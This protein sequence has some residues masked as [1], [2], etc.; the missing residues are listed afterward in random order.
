MGFFD[1]ARN[2]IMDKFGDE[3]VRKGTFGV[4]E[5]Q[6]EPKK[7]A[8]KAP[9]EPKPKVEKP[10]PFPKPKRQPKPKLPKEPRKKV[11]QHVEEPEEFNDDAFADFEESQSTPI[12][13]EP[14]ISAPIS[15]SDLSM[16]ARDE[17][18]SVED[19]L[20]SMSIK[21]TF[22]INDGILFLDEELANQSFATQ[23][24][25]GYDMG[26]VDF[27]LS[28]TQRSVAEYVKLLR[29]RNDDVV[30]LARR[31]SDM[32]VEIN[33]MRFN[34]EVANGINIMANSGDDDALVVDLQEAR[35]KAQRLQ[36]ELEK[37]KNSGVEV[38]S[39]TDKIEQLKN[40]L[41]AE[42]IENRR[43]DTELQDLRAHLVLLEEEYDI[44]VFSERG[45]IQTPVQNGYDSYS[46]RREGEFKNVEGLSTRAQDDL[47]AEEKSYQKVGRDHWLPVVEE[48]LP[49]ITDIEES[50][51]TEDALPIEEG[52]P[53][54][55]DDSEEESLDDFA[56]D[57]FENDEISGNQTTPNESFQGSAFTANPYQDIEEFIESNISHFP[58][59]S[60]YENKD[61]DPDEDGF[62]YSFERN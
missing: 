62:N 13:D 32:M 26:E 54:F 29:V 34:S 20:K 48:G 5:E 30:K 46:E 7:P 56:L 22:T 58:E 4:E 44:E 3:V 21:E 15:S 33:N 35:A 27:F 61:D 39:N 2:S 10:K 12:V 38:E 9:R 60:K 24:P 18:Q 31:I 28:K 19:V 43:L 37:F 45:E 53:L 41:S 16:L 36:E 8:P 6:P 23:A 25:Y 57:T 51:P 17:G 42:R 59:D 55:D 1:K 11:I 40:D 52:L 14:Q 50:L 47:T 49:G